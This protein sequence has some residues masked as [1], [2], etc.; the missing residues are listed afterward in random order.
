MPEI[1]V[2]GKNASP[3]FA[4]IVTSLYHLKV[5]RI[6]TTYEFQTCDEF[7][8]RVEILL[9]NDSNRECW[10]VPFV[11]YDK[12]VLVSFS[13]EDG[14]GNKAILTPSGHNDE[15][16]RGLLFYHCWMNANELQRKILY[17]VMVKPNVDPPTNVDDA[18]NQGEFQGC[19]NKKL[20]SSMWNGP[21]PI[22]ELLQRHLIDFLSEQER[23]QFATQGELT[24]EELCHA[25]YSEF[26]KNLWTKFFQLIWLEE[27]IKPK[28]YG[29]ITGEDQGYMD[30]VASPYN[31]ALLQKRWLGFA[32]STCRLPIEVQPGTPLHAEASYHLRIIPP[33]GVKLD[34]QPGQVATLLRLPR[35]IYSDEETVI[36]RNKMEFFHYVQT[37]SQLTRE[38][39]PNIP[40]SLELRNFIPQ[41]Q[42]QPEPQNLSKDLSQFLKGP[43]TPPDVPTRLESNGAT[44]YFRS[45]KKTVCPESQIHQLS[46]RLDLQNQV[47]RITHWAVIGFLVW[48]LAT[49]FYFMPK[50]Y[51]GISS[52]SLQLNQLWWPIITLMIGEA[53]AVLID[54]SGRP[55]SQQY[56]LRN[57]TLLIVLLTMMEFAFLLVATPLMARTLNATT[58]HQFTGV[59][60]LTL[61][62]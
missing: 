43:T 35:L 55:E 58:I 49:T 29:M 51:L 8:H 17:R 26:F 47:T 37:N 54:Y 44:M 34:L 18:L 62:K 48:A 50:E 6:I 33:E 41:H 25:D 5:K 3:T 12:K 4:D 7:V 30:K 23:S 16:L 31:D 42:H 13:A 19:L 56:F 32:A 59:A 1:K 38:L 57:T 10:V 53:L 2:D 45:E 60:I 52:A 46:F 22:T 27:S 28:H 21:T 24:L 11:M 61:R 15:I 40:A 39:C 36:D 20:K 9:E 14:L